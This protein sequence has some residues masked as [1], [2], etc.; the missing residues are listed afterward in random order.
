LLIHPE[1][2]VP[3][4]QAG[5][6]D[7]FMNRDLKN[8]GETLQGAADGLHSW[9]A[10]ERVSRLHPGP[11]REGLMKKLMEARPLEE[12][13]ILDRLIADATR[14]IRRRW[15]KEKHKMLKKDIVKAQE[16]G[17]ADLC[18]RLLVEK[19]RLLKEE[20]MLGI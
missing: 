20:K 17:N 7:Y 2:I 19:E 5:I 13:K 1:K 3:A 8:F 4:M 11:I 18:S 10:V 12:E 9:D 14:Q 6:L 16:T 15:Y